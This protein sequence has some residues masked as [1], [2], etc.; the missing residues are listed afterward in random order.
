VATKGVDAAFADI[1][2]RYNKNAFIES[3]CHPLMHTIGQA[4][5]KLYP[6][7]SEAYLHGD[8]FCWSGYYHGI[9]EGVA[10]RV[11][12]SNFESQLNTICADIPGKATYSF[13]YYNCLHGLGHG[14]MELNE[15]D[16]FA[17]LKACDVLTGLWEQESCYSGV[18]MENII[19]ESI[20]HTSKYLKASDFLYPCDAVD[21]KY[22]SECYLGQT[23]YAL[24]KSNYDFTKVSALCGTVE[25]P[26][27]DICYQSFGRDAANQAQH[28]SQ[29]TSNTCS[30]GITQ[31]D[32]QNCIVGAVKEFISY[33][34]SDAQAKTFCDIINKSNQAGCLSTTEQYYKQ[35]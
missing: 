26:F 30:L 20:N 22:K 18:F 6:V 23:S 12:K 33:Y 24:E 31:N 15:D 14:V 5:A 1:K 19:A 32:V 11:G 16:V 13:D 35:F 29:K 25:E 28:D 7:V 4:A 34:H 9:L 3:Q 8:S 10:L 17:S 21:S 27:R 2:I